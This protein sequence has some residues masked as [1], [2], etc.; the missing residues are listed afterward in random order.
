MA[1]NDMK[2]LKAE[3]EK[4]VTLL[5][6]LRDEARVRLHLAGMDAKKKWSEL[7]THLDAVEDAA[8][9]T[10]EASRTAVVKGLESLKAFLASL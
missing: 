2:D 4:S 6:T 7:E 9:Q 8:K 3:L 1:S 10:T 5:K